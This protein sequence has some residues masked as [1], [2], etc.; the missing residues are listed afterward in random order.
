[1]TEMQLNLNVIFTFYLHFLIPGTF[2]FPGVNQATQN[3]QE[4]WAKQIL[5]VWAENKE[6]A[7]VLEKVYD[8]MDADVVGNTVVLVTNAQNFPGIFANMK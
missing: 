1:M 2:L 4:S 6:V 7:N 8:R 3:S 5:H